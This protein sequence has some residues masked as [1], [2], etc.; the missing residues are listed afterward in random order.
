MHSIVHEIL[1][2]VYF[3]NKIF[4]YTAGTFSKFTLFK[5]FYQNENERR[6]VIEEHSV[7]CI[8]VKSKSFFHK[9][10]LGYAFNNVT[11]NRLSGHSFTMWL[12]RLMDRIVDSL[13]SS[14]FFLYQ[15]VT[16][17]NLWQSSSRKC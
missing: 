4:I 1:F 5:I 3:I 8:S 11:K 17:I 12:C 7:T 9:I 16:I 14:D 2:K 13:S 6:W 10:E 15:P